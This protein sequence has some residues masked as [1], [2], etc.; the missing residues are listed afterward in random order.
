V[1]LVKNWSSFLNSIVDEIALA[2]LNFT[3]NHF[4]LNVAKMIDSIGKAKQSGVDLIVFS[5]LEFAVTLH[6]I[7]WNTR[8]LL[9]DVVLPFMQLPSIVLV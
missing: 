5:E 1:H 7:C 9:K 2:Q 8:N 6:T 3:V 4:D